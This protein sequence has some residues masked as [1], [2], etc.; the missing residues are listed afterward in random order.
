[1][2]SALSWGDSPRFDVSAVVSAMMKAQSV[3]LNQ[4]QATRKNQDTQENVYD[5][6]QT[7]LKSL[8][9]S[10]NGVKSAF[11][12][13]N[14]TVSSSNNLV[15]TA[16]I[17]GTKLGAGS[18]ALVV[19]QLARAQSSS[20]AFFGSKTNDAG[21]SGTLTIT[22]NQG[23]QFNIDTAGKSLQSI[24]DAINNA[25]DNVGVSATVVMSLAN[26]NVTPQYDL[27]I[28]SKQTGTTNGFNFSGTAASALNFTTASDKT[29]QDA[30]F[31]FDGLNQ[32]QASNNVTNVIDGLNFSL[33][34]TGSVNL[35]INEDSANRTQTVKTSIK[36]M[37]DAYN[38][39]VNFIDS[40]AAN[41]VIDPSVLKY[42]KQSLAREFT[43][44]F[45]KFGEIDSIGMA[46]II[47][48][49]T[50]SL[51]NAA[52]GQEYKSIGSLEVNTKAIYSGQSRFDKLL[53]NNFADL[54]NFF[55]DDTNGFIA[56]V[57]DFISTN[58]LQVGQKNMISNA[59]KT[60]KIQERTLDNQIFAE[61]NRLDTLETSLTD[62]YSKL[63]ALLDKY[64]K[65]T[66]A[67]TKQFDSFSALLKK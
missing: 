36:S 32:V 29:A 33:L 26:D 64:D 2:K 50:Q 63:S 24:A 30:L 55:T 9:D 10:L 17:T 13:I 41:S 44:N 14:Y 19:T 3:R 16:S 12:T 20:S 47:N 18:H 8:Q 57:S 67:L 42:V 11:K 58:Y 7:L 22:N 37:L 51:V 52:S 49:P 45:A 61:Q 48:S 53:A 35:T 43:G 28:N 21:V 25:S 62:Q 34:T 40:N 15:A 60:L 4:M 39:I 23:K 66:Q 59:Q 31:T 56:K 1:M 38:G 5:K 65:Q 46:G 6:L 27:V 54:S